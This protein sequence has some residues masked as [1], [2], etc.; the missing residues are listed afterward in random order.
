MSEAVL[1][2]EDYEDEPR[3]RATV[4]S[5]E[6]LTPEAS[7]AEVRELVLEIERDDFPY[8]VGQSVGVLAPGSPELG[9]DVHLRL[10]SVADLPTPGGEGSGP[11]IKI[12]VRRV[13]Y[14]DDY[15]GER[16]PGIASNYLCD[17]RAGDTLAL[18]GPFGMPFEVPKEKDAVLILIGAGTGIAPFRTLVKHLYQDEVDWHGRVILFHGARSGLELLYMNDEKDDFSQYYDRGTFEA[19]RALSQ[20]PH[21][22]EPIAWD[23]AIGKRG[24]EIWKMLGDPK[25]Y[26]YVAGLETLRPQLDAVFSRLAGGATQWARRRAEL[27]AGGRWVEVL[28]G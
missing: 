17:L 5:T 7:S 4:I 2:W 3:F 1:R 15:S 9:Y 12:C 25:T 14:V 13:T 8:R 22:D 19:I 21:W 20:R 10:Y 11:R 6:R 24:E 27:T 26:V 28:Y 16:Y 18:V 23:Q